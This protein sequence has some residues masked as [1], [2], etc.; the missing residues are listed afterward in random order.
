MYLAASG[1]SCSTWDS[2]CIMQDPSLWRT[3]SRALGFSSWAPGL[4]G[5]VAHGILVLQ[6][7]IES[8]SPALQGRFLTTGSA[9]KSL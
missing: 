8:M 5:L 9:G 3:D 7:G 1:L 4:S 6:P 2:C